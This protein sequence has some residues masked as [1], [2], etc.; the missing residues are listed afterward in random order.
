MRRIGLGPAQHNLKTTTQVVIR[1][2]VHPLTRRYKT[3]II[4]GYNAWSLNTT[5]Y[6]NILFPKFRSLNGNTCAQIFTD[7]EFISLNPSKSKAEEGNGLTNF[8]DDIIIPMNMRF[9][10][11]AEFLGERTEFMKSINKHSINWNVTEPYSHW[12]NRTEDGIK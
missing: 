2:A 6:L 7:T 5:M 12:Q 10:H 8:T 3:D 1:H 11:A 9:D 4:H